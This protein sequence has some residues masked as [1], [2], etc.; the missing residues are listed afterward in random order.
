MTSISHDDHKWR[1]L[2]IAVGLAILLSGGG[3]ASLV[4]ACFEDQD[5]LL[6]ASTCLSFLALL[7]G[8]LCIPLFIAR[9]LQHPRS[10][11]WTD[12][13]LLA[14]PFAACIIPFWLGAIGYGLGGHWLSG[15]CVI[16]G[17]VSCILLVAALVV[18]LLLAK[19]HGSDL[20]ADLAIAFNPKRW[21]ISLGTRLLVV[22]MLAI[23]IGW[24]GM[25]YF[26]ARP[27]RMSADALEK[28]GGRVSTRGVLSRV[29]H[30]SFRGGSG[31]VTDTHLV[32]LE[33]LVSL[34]HLGLERQ[35]ITDAG[36]VHLKELTSLKSLSLTGTHITDAGLVHL[37]GL[38]NLTSL[39][40]EKTQVTD[41][42]LV[43]LRGLRKLRYLPLRNTQVTDRGKEGFR[44]S[45]PNC[46]FRYSWQHPKYGE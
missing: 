46:K 30:V 27:Q 44:K 39:S 5:E 35:E 38:S 43:H 42:G 28:L 13:L 40:L 23:C 41:D 33:G 4:L 45:L 9:H 21:K 34:E 29:V 2:Q 19:H 24:F 18:S 31:P 22:L 20:F 36:L 26:S 6:F 1:P 11:K 17:M 12:I 7:T 16:G 3:L 37:K 8:C 14:I 10:V 32:H 15:P 25:K